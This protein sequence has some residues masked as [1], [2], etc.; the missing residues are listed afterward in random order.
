MRRIAP[1]RPLALVS[2][3]TLVAA[4]L[5]V[6]LPAWAGAAT[7]AV[8]YVSPSGSDTAGNGSA[9]APYATLQAAVSQAPAG[10][11]ILLEPGT[12]SGSVTIT[13]PLT[14]AADPANPGPVV[15]NA[16]GET[17]GI[18]ITGSASNTT[19]RGLTIE[20]AQQAGLL[21]MGPLTN[22]TIEDNVIENNDQG[23]T[24]AEIA[25]NIDFEALHLAGVSDSVVVNNS[26]VNNLDGGIYLTDEP[27]PT[28]DN[29]VAD[30]TVANN[31]V[32][33]GITLASHVPGHG[34]FD[35]TVAHNTVTG[36]GAA[37]I[38]LA[39]PVPNGIVSSNVVVGNTVSGNHLGGISLHTHVPGSQVAN[40][41]IQDNSVG[42]NA[43]M[44]LGGNTTGIEILPEGSP[45]TGT[46]VQGNT[47]SGNLYGL[48]QAPWLPGGT[49]VGANVFKNDTIDNKVGVSFSVLTGLAKLPPGTLG[50]NWTLA[51]T[52]AAALVGMGVTTDN[53]YANILRTALETPANEQSA[54][55]QDVALLYHKFGVIY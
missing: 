3:G 32:D 45:I 23:I 29:V 4:G 30:N 27:G 38:I 19:I 46:I 21:A 7:A 24:P 53:Q 11:T 8:I 49:V 51:Q 55:Q 40:N 39:T 15:L 14:V 47:I 20:N 18:V 31:Q 10:S 36:N 33:C 12:Y 34:V 42:T 35:N 6:A 25:N 28:Q 26:V 16:T 22:L 52:T 13:E 43:D 48:Y 54:A 1:K 37:G 5:M 2:A 44:E 41:I 50:A 9:S 17:N